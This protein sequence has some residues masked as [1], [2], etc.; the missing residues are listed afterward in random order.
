MSRV[1]G[2][3][4]FGTSIGDVY[5]TSKLGTLPNDKGFYFSLATV[6]ETTHT[7]QVAIKAASP[8]YVQQT[9][10]GLQQKLHSG[11][12]PQLDQ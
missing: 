12:Q 6:V 1:F 10:C 5:S 3:N 11:H 4:F 9:L 7:R 2:S 8:K